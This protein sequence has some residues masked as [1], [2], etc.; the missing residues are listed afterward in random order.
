MHDN[1][2]IVRDFLQAS[3]HGDHNTMAILL[4]PDAEIREAD[5]LPYAG[6]HYG[7]EGFLS[8][9]KTVF[10][11]F[12]NTQVMV[13]DIIGEG[14]TVIVLASMSG[15]SKHSDESFRMPVAEVWRLEDGR[16]RNITPF[17]YDTARLNTLAGEV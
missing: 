14:D 5:T 17:Y 16:I 2:Q 8:L 15:H 1:K 12:R 4:H 3:Q 10:T 7:L 9:V 13:E 11:S 6:V